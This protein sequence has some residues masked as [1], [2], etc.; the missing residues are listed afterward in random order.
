M[1]LQRIPVVR[2]ELCSLARGVK[3]GEGWRVVSGYVV[4]L[5]F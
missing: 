1:S 3:S 5:T 4:S 2:G